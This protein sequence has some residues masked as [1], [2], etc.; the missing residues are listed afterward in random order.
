MA[1][2]EHPYKPRPWTMLLA[3][4]FFAGVAAVMAHAAMT[5]DRGL[6]LNGIIRLSPQGATNFYWCIA[7]LGAAFV[8]VGL[9]LF[10]MGL[11][12]KACI[13]LTATELSMPRSAFSRTTR[14]VSLAQIQGTDVHAVNGQRF[15]TVL[16]ADGEVS[17]AQSMLPNAA[18]FEE[19]CAALRTAGRAAA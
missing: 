16:L 11:T 2:I 5:N 15:L 3:S 12:S 19:I 4:A 17:I 13:R 9:P 10:V 14:V 18:A 8:V 6:I 7:G 1:I